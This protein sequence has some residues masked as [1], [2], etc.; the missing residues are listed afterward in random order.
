M[1]RPGR[2]FFGG[3]VYHVYNRLSRGFKPH[4]D[5]V[6]AFPKGKVPGTPLWT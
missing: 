5:A 6:E 3:A 1:P 2:E 4:P